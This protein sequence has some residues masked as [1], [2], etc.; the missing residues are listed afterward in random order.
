MVGE[1]TLA[2][3]NDLAALEL[4]LVRVQGRAEAVRISTLMGSRSLRESG[5]FAALEAEHR[6]LLDAYRGQD[7]AE[8]R[9]RLALCRELSTGFDLARF[10]DIYEARIAGFE[11]APPGPG[12]NGVFEAETK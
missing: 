4:D 7:W 3:A 5:D 11:R 10:Y 1:N 6:A 8:A 2:G 12:W 9:R